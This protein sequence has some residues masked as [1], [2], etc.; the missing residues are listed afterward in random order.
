M[1]LFVD[2]SLNVVA[3]PW[4]TEK[5]QEV[6]NSKRT[7]VAVNRTIEY[8]CNEGYESPNGTDSVLVSCG[9]VNNE[10]VPWTWNDT[11]IQ[12]TFSCVPG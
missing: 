10:T 5:P 1:D 7:E 4:C 2:K 9:T 8:T 11:Y 3:V 6:E 12:D